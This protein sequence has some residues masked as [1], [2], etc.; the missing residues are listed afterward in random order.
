MDL[1]VSIPFYNYNLIDSLRYQITKKN[2]QHYFNI[3]KSLKKQN[4]NLYLNLIGSENNK[5]YNLAKS[6]LSEMVKYT[7]FNQ[8]H[9]E[10]IKPEDLRSKYNYCFET[11]KIYWGDNCKFHCISGSNDFVS[12]VFFDKL[13]NNKEF[14]IIGVS[15][16]K[17]INNLIVIDY[18]DK[19]GFLSTG[20]YK[21]D[22]FHFQNNFIGGFYAL[23]TI[24]LEK[25]NYNPF[26][27][28]N[29]ELGLE[30]YCLE[31]QY[32]L[33]MIDCEIL[34]VKSNTDLNTFKDCEILKKS[35]LSVEQI[36]TYFNYLDSL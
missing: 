15:A 17:N 6:F 30:K 11:A 35:D 19:K 29:D 5:S 31:Q 1:T 27:F 2:I 10:K 24:L 36:K 9:T 3:Q 14:D 25:L 33:H 7:E 20:A 23:N 18:A 4:I 16:N 12:P 34:N 32:K 13:F 28:N 26:Q 21:D 22:L 8:T